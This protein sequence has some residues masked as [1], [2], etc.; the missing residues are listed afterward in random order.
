MYKKNC[1]DSRSFYDLDILM[2]SNRSIDKLVEFT[3]SHNK[4]LPKYYK[5]NSAF[6]QFND[7]TLQLVLDFAI[8]AKSHI[9][10]LIHNKLQ[11]GKLYE[12]A[13]MT[14]FNN[15]NIDY[16]IFPLI[17]QEKRDDIMEKIKCIALKFYAK[18]TLLYSITCLELLYFF[19]LLVNPSYNW[20]TIDYLSSGNKNH[21][22]IINIE[23]YAK[24]CSRNT[25]L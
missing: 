2:K 25:H 11:Y 22:Y 4:N 12:L 15:I 6:H 21:Q 13:R 20:I 24:T 7:I 10:E 8:H 1:P 3:I 5:R 18:N 14:K 9:D 19:A 16:S 17:D 23:T